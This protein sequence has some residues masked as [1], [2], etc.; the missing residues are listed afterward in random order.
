MMIHILRNGIRYQALSV[1]NWFYFPTDE[2]SSPLHFLQWGRN[3]SSSV[4]SANNNNNKSREIIFSK[5]LVK[6]L[7]CEAL[8]YWY[9][10]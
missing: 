7:H 6:Y 4:D 1:V 10:D 2:G 5:L 9:N 3:A 8:Y